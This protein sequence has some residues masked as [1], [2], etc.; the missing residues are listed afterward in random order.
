VTGTASRLTDTTNR[1]IDS[2][3]EAE[4]ILDRIG[5]DVVRM[6]NRPDVDQYYVNSTGNDE[7]F[8]YCQSPG[9][10]STTTTTSQQSPISLVGFR[11][12]TTANPASA[13]S[14][15]RA[16]QGLTWSAS[17]GSPFLVFPAR[18]SVTQSL[19]AT[20]GTIPSLWGTVVNDPDTSPSFWHT[21]G[22][23]VFRLEIC[24]QLRDGTFTLTPPSSSSPP[25]ASTA[26]TSPLPPVP[27]SVNDTTGLVVSIALLDT[28]SRQMVP[29]TSWT[30]LI[31][32]LPD[33]SQSDLSATP[34]RLM[35]SVW[36]ARLNDSAFASV[37]GIPP[38][39]AAQIR[40]YQ[41]IYALGVPYA[42]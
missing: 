8:F 1:N 38:A 30:S 32:A 29:A 41:R 42:R 33:P 26:T 31:A 27:G 4:Q 3:S 12:S 34:V 10:F 39:A 19:A 23:Q 40:V 22:N 14:L 18:T 15:E 36:K 17:G 2:S 24:Y 6:I 35:E 13:P 9:Y 5:Q 20:A 28:K 11:I 21:I 7:F 25:T 37:A 16:A